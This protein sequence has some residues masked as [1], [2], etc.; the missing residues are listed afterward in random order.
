M[1]KIILLVAAGMIL[2]MAYRRLRKTQKKLKQHFESGK[3]EV[4][5]S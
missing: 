1:D 5:E 2:L 3:K 4:K